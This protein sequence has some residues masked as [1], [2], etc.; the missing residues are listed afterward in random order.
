MYETFNTRQR[1]TFAHRSYSAGA[2]GA[3]IDKVVETKGVG[4]LPKL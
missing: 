2:S 1:E 3:F 4:H